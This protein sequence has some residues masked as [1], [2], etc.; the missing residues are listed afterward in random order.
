MQDQNS[1]SANLDLHLCK[2]GFATLLLYDEIDGVE[3][4]LALP[5]SLD[6]DQRAI[7]EFSDRTA[8]RRDVGA[9]VLGQALLARKA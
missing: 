3:V 1:A 7:L 8:H 4:R 5:P 2:S 9:H 6:F